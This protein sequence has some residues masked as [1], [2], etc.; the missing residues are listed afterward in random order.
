MLAAIKKHGMT[1]LAGAL[2][3]WFLSIGV[4]V[5]VSPGWDASA[6]ERILWGTVCLAAAL[7]VFGG[8]VGMRRGTRGS[9]I[10]LALGAV[11]GAAFTFWIVA[12]PVVALA[13]LVWL[14]VTRERRTPKPA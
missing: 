8:L 7:L 9:R 12:P 2:G 10:A 6:G 4:T 5:S 11:L 14:F 3:I 13:V 1:A